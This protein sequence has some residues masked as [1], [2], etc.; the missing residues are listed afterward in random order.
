MSDKKECKTCGGIEVVS[1]GETC[2]YNCEMGGENCEG[3]TNGVVD[4]KDACNKCGKT[5]PCPKCMPVA[6]EYYLLFGRELRRANLAQREV[7]KLEKEINGLE[8]QITGWYKPWEQ[9]ARKYLKVLEDKK[10]CPDCGT[11]NGPCDCPFG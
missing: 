3:M 1:S 9:S 4:N 6:N 10:I 8:G 7:E 2:Y 11:V 5:V